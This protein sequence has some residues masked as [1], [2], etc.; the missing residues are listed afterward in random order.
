MTFLKVQ[1]ADVKHLPQ[2]WP[3]VKNYLENALKYTEDY[4][5]DQIK[6]FLST[7]MWV[8]FVF[9]DEEQRIHGAMTVTFE[10]SP[11]HRTAI[12]TAIG[13]K[14]VVTKPIIEQLSFILKQNGA[15]RIQC[16][17]RDSAARLYGTIG[18][19]KKSILME[20]KI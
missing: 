9:V 4:T 17:A 7:N 13:G 11:N 15:N 8:L 19:C 3:L 16:L 18:F 20:L 14:N 1:L 5:I 10:N 6:V 12:I 2:I